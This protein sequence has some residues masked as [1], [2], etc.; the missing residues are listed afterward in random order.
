LK[1]YYEVL[2][3]DRSANQD[4]IKKA[5]RNLS[6]QYH[7]DVN[8]DGEARFKEI[9]EAYEVLGDPAKKSQYDNPGP[10]P[11]F[12]PFAAF[13]NFQFSTQR[14]AEYLNVTIDRNFSLE[15]LMNGV[16]FTAE[17]R[18]SHTAASQSSFETK[19]VKVR[20]NLSKDHYPITYTNA[21][22]SIILRVRGGG[23]S[24]MVDAP[25]FFGR[26]SRFKSV[27]DLIVKINVDL[28][29]LEI[30]GFDLVQRV[31]LT[32]AQLLFADEIIL[33]NPLGKKYKITSIGSPNLSDIK[34]RVPG[35]G[36]VAQNGVKGAYVFEIK[37][38]YPKITNLD[39]TE[40]ATFKE[41]ANKI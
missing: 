19:S 23:N 25:D 21:G 7:P 26:P 39:E 29:G 1:N 37:V 13:G 32:L 22:Q 28:M 10:G 14:D 41:I 16:D 15:E 40:L 6:K 31:E 33:K 38:I 18:T 27:G 2:G 17:Y 34:I 12:D 30:S 5:Y 9:A 24:Q 20:A 8:P 3:V 11:R 36:L 35:M 4:E